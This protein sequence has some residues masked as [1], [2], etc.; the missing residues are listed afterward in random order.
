MSTATSPATTWGAAAVLGLVSVVVLVGGAISLDVTPGG[1]PAGTLSD[2]RDATPFTGAGGGCTIFDPT[3]TGGCVT[4]AT[5]WLLQQAGARFGQQPTSCWDAH[6]W[7][8]T[9][10]HPKGRGCDVTFGTAG[11]FPGESDKAAGWV[12]AMWLVSNAKALHVSYVIWQ[13]QI[14]STA[15]A[16]EGWRT[17]TGGG[18]YDPTSPVGGHYDH[19]HVSVLP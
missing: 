14:W 10:D 15:R 9:S 16:G 7:N 13:G 4:P 1:P 8:P 11:R 19:V 6:A 2:T 18:V 12:F 3:G 5:A 17:Y